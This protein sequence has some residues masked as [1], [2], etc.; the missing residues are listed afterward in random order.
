M[1]NDSSLNKEQI[2]QLTALAMDLAREGKITELTEFLDH[3][4]PIDIQDPDGNTL[5]MLAAYK[6]EVDTV[7]MLLNRGANVDI[8][9]NRDQSPSPEPFSRVKRLFA[10]SLWRPVPI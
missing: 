7:T 3:G 5:L 9:N 8:R 1:N 6:G 10:C 4:F 2:L